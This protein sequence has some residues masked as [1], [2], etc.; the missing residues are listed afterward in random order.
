MRKGKIKRIAMSVITMM[1]VYIAFASVGIIDT[2]DWSLN[3]L[4]V[5]TCMFIVSTAW[6]YMFG[7]AN[8]L[9]DDD[10]E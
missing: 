8:G 3:C 5:Q 6:I 10:E 7:K 1:A 4:P 9:M 2:P